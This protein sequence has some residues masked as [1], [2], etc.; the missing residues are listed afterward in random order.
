MQALNKD[1]K[2]VRG[3]AIWVSERRPFQKEEET[4]S[5]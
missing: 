1:L 4:G 3:Q 2:E 5:E